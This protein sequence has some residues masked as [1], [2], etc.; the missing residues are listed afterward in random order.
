MMNKLVENI[1]KQ[2]F[3]N[4]KKEKIFSTNYNKIITF[5][6]CPRLSELANG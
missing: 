1:E 4:N 3:E 2:Y 5:S 6:S